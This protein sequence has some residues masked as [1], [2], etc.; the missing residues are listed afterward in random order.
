MESV[1]MIWRGIP[2]LLYRPFEDIPGVIDKNV[3]GSN[4]GFDI[5]NNSLDLRIARSNIKCFW[6]DTEWNEISEL[7]DVARGR[8]DGVVVLSSGNGELAAEPRRTA[9]DEPDF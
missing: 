7:R 9:G 8:H 5:V 1:G 2:A 3:N 4:T 6:D